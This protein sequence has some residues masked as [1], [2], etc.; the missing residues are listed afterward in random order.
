MNARMGWL[1]NKEVLNKEGLY[2]LFSKKY[3]LDV[4]SHGVPPP[5]AKETHPTEPPLH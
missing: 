5:P 4:F 3:V 2:F 1:L